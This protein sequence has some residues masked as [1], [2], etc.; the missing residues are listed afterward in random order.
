[1]WGIKN[2]VSAWKLEGNHGSREGGLKRERESCREQKRAM[3]HACCEG[4]TSEGTKG[5]SQRVRGGQGGDR[6]RV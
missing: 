5:T 1:M 4:G 6:N 2:F 3:G